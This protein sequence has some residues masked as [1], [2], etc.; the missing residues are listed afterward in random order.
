[1]RGGQHL[2]RAR[3]HRRG[4]GPDGPRSGHR[5]PLRT[6]RVCREPANAGNRDPDGD[7]RRRCD[8]LRMVLRQGIV[9]AL[10]GLVV[11]LAA[12]VGAGELL[13]AAFPSGDDQHGLSS[14]RG[15]RARRFRRDI[16]R[17]V[18]SR[19]PRLADQSD[20]GAAARIGRCVPANADR[21][22]GARLDCL[23]VSLNLLRII[24]AESFRSEASCPRQSPARARGGSRHCSGSS[25]SS[26]PSGS[27]ST[28]YELLM[29]PLIVRP[30]LIELLKVAPNSPSI[31]DWAG[32]HLLCTSR[33]GRHL[34]A[35]RRI[36]HG[37]VRPPRGADMEHPALC[38]S[39]RFWPGFRN[40][41]L[42]GAL[43][44]RC[45]TFVGVCVEFVAAVAWLS[46]LFPYPKQR[47]AIVGY[48]QTAR[49]DRRHH[50]D[51]R[52][53]PGRD[54]R[55]RCCPRCAAGTR[56]GVTR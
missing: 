52:L 6:G 51:S 43:F 42:S 37:R 20:A 30:A 17:R 49:I 55:A 28:P 40:L 4:D 38:S 56:R 27:R 29:L 24:T 16:P 39:R 15:R 7:R 44:W 26:P 19:A 50:G 32:N 45:C 5:R 2:Q 21:A 54:L 12:S 31:N 22:P 8:V 23:V 25:S 18:H 41:R 13:A 53:L 3:R 46:E 36:S 33:G 48:T 10:V 34:R 9:L 14:P 1:M 47:E 11:G 35:A